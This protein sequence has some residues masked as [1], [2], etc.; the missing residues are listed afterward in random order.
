MFKLAGAIVDFYDD[1]DF[2]SSEKAQDLIKEGHLKPLEEVPDL[3]DK[4][5]AV[6]ILTKAGAHRKFP[7]FNKVATTLSG[8]YFEEIEDGLPM[9]I[10]KVAG[11]FL[12]QAHEVFGIDSTPSLLEE[13]E[14]PA[15]NEVEYRP[16]EDDG[17]V[18]SVEVVVKLAQYSFLEHHRSMTPIEKVAKAIEIDQAIRSC[19]EVVTER[20]V[21]DY[22]PKEEYG[23]G[24]EDM[25]RQRAA[26]V[27]EAGTKVAAAFD[28]IL[29]EFAKMI[30]KEGP[31]LIHQFD[32]TAGFDYR[33]GL[34]G[35][36]DPFYGAWA[37]LPLPKKEAGAKEDLL[38]H[39]LE[40]IAHHDRML[41]R[42]FSE[43]FVTKFIADPKG[44]YETATPEQKKVLDFIVG[45]I[46]PKKSEA[47]ESL[48]V[49]PKF[50]AKGIH[51]EIEKAKEDLKK[52]QV[53]PS[54]KPTDRYGGWRDSIY[55]AINAGL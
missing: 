1:P 49:R 44:A 19:G 15:H 52:K 30:P 32:K 5:F 51:S 36:E 25:L 29:K 46:P 7:I 10:R 14:V 42:T 11:F 4:D 9:E 54:E 47:D 39:K 55:G 31:F 35:V 24:V 34:G 20:E 45:H 27:K 43:K 22:V 37:G 13:F 26:L 50:K 18:R 16:E 3:Q 6:K 12:K 41:K 2:H 53:K 23:R 21:W 28:E 38:R 8:R 40:T 17:R 48:E 33:Y